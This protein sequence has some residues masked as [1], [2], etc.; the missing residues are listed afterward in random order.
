M[1]QIQR[2]T[3]WASLQTL[4]ASALNG[5][6]N[7]IVNTWN[8]HD[9][10]TSSWT[11]VKTAALTVTGAMAT[12][13]SSNVTITNDIFTTALTDYS[14]T[15]TITGWTSFT[16]KILKYKK[17]G[18]TMFVYFDIRGTSNA[19]T[20]SL[21]LPVASNSGLGVVTSAIQVADNGSNPT[22]PGE[23]SLSSGASTLNFYKDYSAPAWTNS[24]TKSILGCFVYEA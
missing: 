12:D 6:F 1:S 19:T 24:G 7:N 10:G 5:E 22:T 8:N 4:T 13:G 15:S 17:L 3:T 23:A 18:K 16:T 2:Q 14:G 11:S 20:T 9:S 21:T